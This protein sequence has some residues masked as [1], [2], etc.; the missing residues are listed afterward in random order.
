M[1]L[2]FLPVEEAINFACANMQ[3]VK[4]SALALVPFFIMTTPN[5]RHRIAPPTTKIALNA[6]F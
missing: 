3:I 4:K 6:P 2:D 5:F 1:N